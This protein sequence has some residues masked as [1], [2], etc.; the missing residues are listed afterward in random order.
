MPD[1]RAPVEKTTCLAAEIPLPC[2]ARMAR[3]RHIP[4]EQPALKALRAWFILTTGERWFVIGAL[5]IFLIGLVARRA[6][7]KRLEAT[8]V[9]PP[10]E[11]APNPGGLRR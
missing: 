9:P 11:A 8:P 6:H 2:R 10:A 4:V 5:A 1:P 7:L 3:R